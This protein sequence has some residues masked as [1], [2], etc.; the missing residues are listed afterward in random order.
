MNN[1]IEKYENQLSLVQKDILERLCP[2][3]D[4]E[5]YKN[6]E[7]TIILQ[8]LEDLR[9]LNQANV[10]NCKNYDWID[11]AKELPTD[12]RKVLVCGTPIGICTAHYWGVNHKNE[13][14]TACNGWSIMGV[15]HWTEIPKLPNGESEK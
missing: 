9:K 10:I 5:I 4:M 11:I 13:P 3:K 15:T 6:G 12:K 8:I 2:N 7:Q 14:S 1:L